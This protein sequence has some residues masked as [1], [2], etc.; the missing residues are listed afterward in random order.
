MAPSQ[1]YVTK[2]SRGPADPEDVIR[3]VRV[4]ILGDGEKHSLG[5]IRTFRGQGAH[6]GPMLLLLD[7]AQGIP[8]DFRADALEPLR[9][10]GAIQFPPGLTPELQLRTQLLPFAGTESIRGKEHCQN[11]C[12]HP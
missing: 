12:E 11:G 4:E 5:G 9:R 6:S 7:V 8:N 10:P 3:T 1:T 2:C